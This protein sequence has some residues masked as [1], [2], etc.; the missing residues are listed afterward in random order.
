NSATP[1]QREKL[2][3]LLLGAV[4]ESLAPASETPDA[5][6]IMLQ[7]P[8]NREDASTQCL[9][10]PQ[11]ANLVVSVWTPETADAPLAEQESAWP[12]RY[13]SAGLREEK[14]AYIA[15]NELSLWMREKECKRVS[16]ETSDFR[17]E[18]LQYYYEPPK[19]AF[20]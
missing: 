9:R 8:L 14:Q 6:M 12:E 20:T 19:C 5:K 3:N 10:D 11:W 2:E 18:W 4:K 13:P 16:P 1:E 15:R 17:A 7:T